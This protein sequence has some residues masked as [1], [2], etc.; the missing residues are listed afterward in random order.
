MDKESFKENTRY[1]I[2]WR[3]PDG[4]LRPANIY[5]YKMFE[6]AMIARMTDKSGLL[7]KIGYDDVMR[8]VKTNPV[9]NG[10]LFTIPAAI[11]DEKVWKDRTVMERYSSAPQYGK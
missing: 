3:S 6:K 5:V 9:D 1:T 7:H 4:K 10:H 8:I 2:T 11:L